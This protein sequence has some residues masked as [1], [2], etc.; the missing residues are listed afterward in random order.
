VARLFA[1][2]LCEIGA[3]EGSEFVETTG[4]TLA[5]GG[6]SALQKHIDDIKKAKGG[7]LFLDEAY[8]LNPKGDPF[9]GRKVLDL[10]LTEMENNRDKLVVVFAGY[11]KNMEE[12]MEYNEGLPSRFPNVFQFADFNDSELLEILNQLLSKEL[13]APRKFNIQDPAWLRIVIR[14]LA[15]RR[16]KIGFGNARDVR[17]LFELIKKRQAT[18]LAQA[19]M[20]PSGPPPDLYTLTREDILGP[21]VLREDLQ[22][23][24]AYQKLQKLIGLNEVK[25]EVDSIL[26]LVM[27]N[28]DK[29]D[30]EEPTNELLL[31]RLFL[32]NPGTL[33]SCSV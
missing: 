21:R 29:E 25:K 33:F 32:G 24:E 19:R 8:Q 23:L 14:R 1:K 16:G 18:R 31:N 9:G 2:I 6:T 10:L 17:N 28:F 26:D 3:L 27:A 7:V 20:N 11:K 13:A 5:S 30:K 15:K 22:S 12:L 4:A